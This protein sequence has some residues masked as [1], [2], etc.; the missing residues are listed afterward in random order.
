[1]VSRFSSRTSWDASESSYAAAMREVRESGR[2]LYDLTISNPTRCGFSYD[3]DALLGP[4]ADARALMYDPD[5]RGMVLAR[6]AVASYYG[7]DLQDV[8]VV[9]IAVSK[10]F[11]PGNRVQA[12]LYGS[13]G[14]AP[15]PVTSWPPGPRPARPR[16]P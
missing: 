9:H 11:R 7:L 3:A 16:P 14:T 12:L 13:R 2:L 8:A 1:M 4:L 10:A 15:L 5:P 6:E